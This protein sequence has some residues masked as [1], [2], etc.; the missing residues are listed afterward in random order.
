MLFGQTTTKQ[1]RKVKDH[2]AHK[3]DHLKTLTKFCELRALRAFVVK[4][5]SAKEPKP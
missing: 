4:K 5:N 1:E 3:E 2:E